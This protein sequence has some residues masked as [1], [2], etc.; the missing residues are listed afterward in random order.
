[1][2]YG[3]KYSAVIGQKNVFLYVP[4]MNFQ[5]MGS[6]F[7]ANHSAVFPPIRTL[8]TGISPNDSA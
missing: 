2:M 7:E 1:M 4:N 6:F 8:N 3:R 5:A